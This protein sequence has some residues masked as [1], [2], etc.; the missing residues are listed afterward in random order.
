M[1]WT[2]YKVISDQRKK[3]ATDSEQ[4]SEL[5]ATCT[6][7]ISDNLIQFSDEIKYCDIRKQISLQTY[8]KI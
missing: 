5:I 7:G 1:V 3:S 4:S 6:V 8:S 2:W